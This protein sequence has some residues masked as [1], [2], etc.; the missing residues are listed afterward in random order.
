VKDSNA[1]K[2]CGVGLKRWIAHRAFRAGLRDFAEGRDG[3]DQWAASTWVRCY[4]EGRLLAAFTAQRGIRANTMPREDLARAYDDADRMF[5]FPPATWR[6]G[7]RGIW[8]GLAEERRLAE[9]RAL[10]SGA[11]P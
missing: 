7:R 5:V 11:A 8:A 1:G 4:E 2:L 6:G 10:Y 9:S 3:F